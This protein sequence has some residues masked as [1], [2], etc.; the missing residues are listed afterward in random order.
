MVVLVL[1]AHVAAGQKANKSPGALVDQGVAWFCWSVRNTFDADDT[2]RG[3]W[4]DEERC[5]ADLHGMEQQVG[6]RGESTPCAYQKKA[7]AFSYFDVMKDYRD[8]AIY[9]SI[10]ECKRGRAFRL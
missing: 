9:A 8:V 5:A 4:R 1:S 7:A 3:C 2:T 10:K 6:D